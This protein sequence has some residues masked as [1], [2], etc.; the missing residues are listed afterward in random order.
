MVLFIFVYYIV[1]VIIYVFFLIMIFF[2][3]LNNL[4]WQGFRGNK[5]FFQN[6][7][8]VNLK[9]VMSVDVL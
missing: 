7:L 6:N 5:N 1:Q 9:L 4:E 8:Y 2:K 3:L